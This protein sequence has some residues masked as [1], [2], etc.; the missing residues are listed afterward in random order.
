MSRSDN[1]LTATISGD[2]YA[3]VSNGILNKKVSLKDF[4]SVINS[5]ISQE[6]QVITNSTTRYPS[7]VHS[8]IRTNQGYVV[9]LYFPEQEATV[10]HSGH[11]PQTIYMPNVM[12]RVELREIQGKQGEYS[13]GNINWYATDKNRT[14]LTTDWPTSGNTRDH[15]W[16]LPFPNIFGNASM[17]TG[18]NRLP[19]VIYSDW[20]ILDMLYYDVLIG[21][22]FN[23]DLSV[24]S[25]KTSTIARSWI[26][27][28][29][30]HWKDEDTERFP[31]DLLTNY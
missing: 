13:L 16:T 10:T 8:V 12:I 21:S 11:T 22:P 31:Y 3:E 5:L 14:A 6:D 7:S 17:C 15:I 24:P 27:I 30:N 4:A 1:T 9:N 2:G 29:H 20:T 28:L 26:N 23:N 25:I 19:S 18:G